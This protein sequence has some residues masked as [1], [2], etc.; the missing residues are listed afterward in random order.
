MDEEFESLLAK[1][2]RKALWAFATVE[3]GSQ[4]HLKGFSKAFQRLF[5]VFLLKL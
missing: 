2:S 3:N 1:S 4:S 5:N